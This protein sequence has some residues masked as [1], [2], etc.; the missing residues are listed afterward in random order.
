MATVTVTKGTTDVTTI[1]GTVADGDTV[2]FGEGSQTITTGLTKLS[3]DN[4]EPA[5]LLVGAGFTGAIGG[6]AG[7]LKCSVTTLCHY[8]ASGGQFY[9]WPGG[10]G[11]AI[12][13]MKAVSIGGNFYATTGGTLTILEAGSGS[14]FVS[15]SVIV[16]TCYCTGGTL[17]ALYNGTVFTLFE[18][19]GGSGSIQRGATTFT[20][21]A[22][23]MTIGRDDTSATAPAFTTIT[24]G[25]KIV[26]QAALGNI[27]TL[28][29]VGNG[30]VDLSNV[31]TPLT[32]GT[33][34]G[35]WDARKRS[36]LT[37]Q[38]ATITIITTNSPRGG[39]DD[40]AP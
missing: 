30:S 4:H 32:I 24:A 3:D 8:G 11:T 14:T 28:N 12:A 5:I 6:A 23:S 36:I 1:L 29:I 20:Q 22:G 15:D 33:L 9:L 34:N 38:Y 37:S 18:Q 31:R 39:R 26:A 40:V 16:T 21:Y 7:S 27:T 10:T 13:R 25:G 17:T 35:S 2:I 19:H